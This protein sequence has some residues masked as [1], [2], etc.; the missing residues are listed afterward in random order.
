M[1]VVLRRILYGGILASLV[2]S[3][4]AQDRV[5]VSPIEQPDLSGVAAP[6]D[7]EAPG[8][9]TS[10]PAA[11][12]YKLQTVVDGE[13]IPLEWRT[14]RLEDGSWNSLFRAGPEPR[15]RTIKP[16]PK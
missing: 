12:D 13:V 9:A 2:A 6:R 16:P 11:T 8:E 4:E 10:L 5:S 1:V 14:L 3:A 7:I 15:Q